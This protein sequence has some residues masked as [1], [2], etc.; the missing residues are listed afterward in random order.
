MGAAYATL[1]VVL[2]RHGESWIDVPLALPTMLGTALSILLGFRTASSYDRWWE[3]RKIWG[4]IVNDS[5][6]FAR[7]VLTLLSGRDGERPVALQRELVYRQ[8]A[9]NYALARSLRGEDPLA[10]AEPYLSGEE[11]AALRTQQNVPN[12]LLQ[13]QGTRLRDAHRRGLLDR[14]FFM[15]VE[16]TLRRLTDHM[17]MC[18]RINSTVF[19][20]HYSFIVSRT[21]LVFGFLLPSGLVPYLGWFTIPVALIIELLFSMIEAAGTVLQSPFEN[22]VTDTPMTALSRT[23][24]INLRQQL[25]ETELP[26]KLQPVDGVLM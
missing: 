2:H 13:T 1:V 10:D 12:A 9:W 17:G 11:I 19:P 6:T 14:F 15:T 24:E 18:E 22:R 20:G 26:E 3:A 16:E 7:Q 25:G 21:L 4:A 8:I 23:I 5:R